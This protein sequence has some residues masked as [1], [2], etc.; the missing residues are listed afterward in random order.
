MSVLSSREGQ[1]LLKLLS[2][3]RSKLED[4]KNALLKNDTESAKAGFRDILSGTGGEQAVISLIE[5]LKN[6]R[7]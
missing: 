3:D 2:K 1:E 6:E 4:L 5:K 7:A